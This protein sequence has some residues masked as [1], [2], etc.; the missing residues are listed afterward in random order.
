MKH[1]TIFQ[2]LA[3]TFLTLVFIILIITPLTS[4]LSITS[5]DTI[6]NQIAPGKTAQLIVEIENDE[7]KTIYDVSISLDLKDLPFAPSDSSAEKSVEK[8]REEKIKTIYFRLIALSN[9]ESGIYKIPVKLT[10]EKDNEIVTKSSLISLIVNSEP[11]LSVEHQ[12]SLVLKG[13]KNTITLKAINKG[14]SDIKFLEIEIRQ[15]VAYSILSSKKAYIGDLDSDDFD[16]NDF[17][18]FIK[19]NAPSLIIIPVTLKYKDVINDDYSKD[20]SVVLRAYSK[21]EALRL[22]LIKKKRTTATLFGIV[23]LIIL[24]IVYRKIR[25]RRRKKLRQLQ[26]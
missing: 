12:D 18:L 25:K 9:A 24:Y 21:E 2:T 7:D 22:G 16:T 3:L 6:P 10:Y 13:Q 17:E 5:V 11:V 4:A 23:V 14:L 15:S 19:A 20:F 26:K 8:I 1:K